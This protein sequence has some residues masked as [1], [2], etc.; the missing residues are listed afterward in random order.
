[1]QRAFARRIIGAACLLAGSA[2]VRAIGV[3]DAVGDYVPGYAGSR[4]GDL[5]VVGAFVTYNP[6]TDR[7]VFSGTL[8]ADLGTTPSGFYVWGIDRGAGTARFAANGVPG[9]LFDTVVVFNLDGSGT[10]TLLAP[11][12][13]ANTPLAAGTAHFVGS[14][15]FAEVSGALLPSMGFAKTAYTWNLWP[16]DGSLP[17]GFGQIADF[18]PDNSNAPVVTVGAIPEP[19]TFALMA[20]GLGALVM[21]RR[22][23]RAA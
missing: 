11:T 7:F 16:R 23:R 21:R 19:A 10:V 8:N 3:T 15:F 14:T 17:A 6:G 13:P 4:A 1:M 2:G 12:P 20:C 5:D 9:V 18:A 22:L